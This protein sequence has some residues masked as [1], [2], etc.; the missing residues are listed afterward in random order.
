MKNYKLNYYFQTC[1]RAACDA[2]GRDLDMDKSQLQMYFYVVFGDY[3]V[4]KV[5]TKWRKVNRRVEYRIRRNIKKNFALTVSDLKYSLI[6]YE[7]TIHLNGTVG[8]L[9][10]NMGMK[11]LLYSMEESFLDNRDFYNRHTV[12]N[13]AKDDLS[14][15][16][17][18]TSVKEVFGETVLPEVSYCSDN[19]QVLEG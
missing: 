7:G 18:I 3:I 15:V 9:V 8:M 13:I 12:N 19:V 6:E 11:Y 2:E 1:I 17:Y 16:D 14:F 10:T 4:F 5:Y